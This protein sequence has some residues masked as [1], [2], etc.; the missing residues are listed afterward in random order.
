MKTQAVFHQNQVCAVSHPG[1]ILHTH[2]YKNVKIKFVI[3]FLILYVEKR[4][5]HNYVAGK[6]VTQNAKEENDVE[7][8]S[9]MEYGM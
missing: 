6:S 9:S 2:N 5:R 7:T 3:F 4:D 8:Y 1:R